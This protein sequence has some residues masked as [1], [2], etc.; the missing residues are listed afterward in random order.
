MPQG[1]QKKNPEKGAKVK[2]FINS[3]SWENINF[4][5]QEKDYQ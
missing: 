3:F 2:P 1:N 5:P 4:P